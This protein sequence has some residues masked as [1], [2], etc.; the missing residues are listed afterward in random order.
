LAEVGEKMNFDLSPEQKIFIDEVRNFMKKEVIPLVQ[1][2][3]KE[4]EFLKDIWKKMSK[5]GLLGM[6]VP[7]KYGGAEVDNITAALAMEEVSKGHTALAFSMGPH[8]CFVGHTISRYGNEEQKNKY[9]P[10]IAS[11]ELIGGGGW[12]EPSAGSDLHGIKTTAVK[13]GDYYIV[14]GSKTLITNAPIANI[15]VTLVLTDESAKPPGLSCFV[16]E[17]GTPGISFGEEMEKMGVL[18][19]PT[20]EIFFDD[21]KVPLE[22][23]LGEENNGFNQLM[24]TFEKGRILMAAMC[25]GTAMACL[26]VAVHYAKTRKAFGQFISN[27][28][29]TKFKIADMKKDI[30]AAHLLIMR[31][32]WLKDQGKSVEME[33]SIAKLFA[34]EISIKCAIDAFQIHGGSGYMK[35]NMVERYLRDAMV[36]TVGEGTSEIQ[37]LIIARHILKQLN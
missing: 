31:A 20:G 28:Q 22:N 29:A 7:E 8:N 2:S 33:G 21:C 18:G 25:L 5:L 36:N 11:G 9:L 27:F 3:E 19:S 14:N 23:R 13:K 26:E 1:E 30:D 24:E 10:G 17:R 34:S 12:T 16:F 15:F 32:A 37:R 35:E 4:K 6:F